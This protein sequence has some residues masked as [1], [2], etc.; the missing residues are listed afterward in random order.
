MNSYTKSIFYESDLE[1]F[2][3]ILLSKF[4]MSDNNGLTKIFLECLDRITKYEEYYRNMYKVDEIIE[5]M[6]DLE[7]SEEQPEEVRNIGRQIIIN[8]NER[9]GKNNL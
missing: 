2:I 9:K 7:S 3:D 1:S 5:L 6:E 4:Q 8:I